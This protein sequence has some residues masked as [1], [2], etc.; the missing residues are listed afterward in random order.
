M[1]RLQR[2]EEIKRFIKENFETHI[3]FASE[4]F[5]GKK[6]SNFVNNESI[7]NFLRNKDDTFSVKLLRYIDKKD[8]E[9]LACYKAAGVSKQTWYKIMN[10]KTYMPSKK[11]VL[12]FGIVLKLTYE[13][14][15][16][17]LKSAGF[18]LSKSSKFDLIIEYCIKRGIYDLYEINQILADFRE[19]T[20]GI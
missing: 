10:E 12:A 20:L 1:N 8:M 14:M 19:G 2:I 15:S 11:T 9:D 5:L 13:E 7:E 4:V 6:E 18:S 16:D 17:L 3:L